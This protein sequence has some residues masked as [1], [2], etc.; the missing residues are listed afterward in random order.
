M[1]L[2]RSSIVSRAVLLVALVAMAI[3]GAQRTIFARSPLDQ[4]VGQ[5]LQAMTLDQR[6][7]QL[8]MVSLYGEELSDSGIM[9][10]RQMTPGAVAMFSYNGTSPQVINQTINRWQS[11]AIQAGAGV[12]LLVAI[13]Q[14]GGTVNRLT[15]GFTALPWGP[16]LGAMPPSDAQAVGKMAGEELSAVGFNMNLAPVVD[17]RT[18][19]DNVFMEKRMFGSDPQV[20][21]AAGARCNQ[22]SSHMW[23]V[24]GLK[25]FFRCSAGGDRAP[26]TIL[27]VCNVSGG[28][29]T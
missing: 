16:A 15:D 1:Q 28:T 20:V 10:L 11:V 9:F 29:F 4:Q 2:S 26:L 8:F 18:R 12:P 5:L 7:G 25:S 14:E 22:G 19:P 27:G 24:F 17:V 23:V 3:P 13:D 6:V 21:A